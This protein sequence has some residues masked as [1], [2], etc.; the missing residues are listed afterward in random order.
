MNWLPRFFQIIFKIL[1]FILSICLICG[2]LYWVTLPS[3]PYKDMA[4]LW[5]VIGGV[6]GIF[7]VYTL[8]LGTVGLEWKKKTT[9]RVYN[10]IFILLLI[11]IIKLLF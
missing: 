11:A 7:I 2:F 1:F 10:P 9:T 4:R 6:A 3:H 5:G 8:I